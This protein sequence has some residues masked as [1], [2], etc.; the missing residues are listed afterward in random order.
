MVILSLC[1]TSGSLRT[2]LI[3][4][5]IV[6][7]IFTII[8]IILVYRCYHELFAS[9]VTPDKLKERTSIL[10][11]NAVAALI[12]F[13]IPS[14]FSL[15]FTYLVDANTNETLS[16]YNEASLKKVN[17]LMQ[18]EKEEA[19]QQKKDEQEK[20]A[21]AIKKKNEEEAKLKENIK[22][23]RENG[24]NLPD[25][26]G[27]YPLMGKNA[28]GGMTNQLE[29]DGNNLT[30]AQKEQLDDYIL[31][32]VDKA[33][34]DWGTRVA[35]AGY[36]LIKGLNNYNLRL[37]Y[38]KAGTGSDSAS[39]IIGYESGCN[40]R[41][42]CVNWGKH[43]T[44]SRINS[45]NSKWDYVNEYS[46]VDCTGFVKWSIGTGC[47]YVGWDWQHVSRGNTPLSEARSGDYL[48]LPGHVAL[49][50]KNLGNGTLII[51]ESTSGYGKIGT[52]FN[53]VNTNNKKYTLVPM[54]D[55]YQSHCKTN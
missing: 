33:G 47:G 28:N 5:I 51:G 9:V 22:N 50:L 52:I 24:A 35:T 18:K 44:Q 46:G 2:F 1:D 29:V 34:E 21:E 49:V 42:Y 43:I 14:L 38:E 15:I 54:Q 20:L 40:G 36:S 45:I 27:D 48:A 25:K 53:T 17:S 19:E 39:S 13:L 7:I 37:H 11:K 8:P 30:N 32:N 55:W 23:G 26:V 41:H 4:K 31:S 3:I 12:I 16:C 6:G 10:A